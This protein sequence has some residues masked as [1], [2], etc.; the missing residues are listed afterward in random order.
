MGSLSNSLP[1]LLGLLFPLRQPLHSR[2]HFLCWRSS[3]THR[4]FP[5]Q[6]KTLP[7]FLPPSKSDASF[8]M[9]EMGVRKLPSSFPRKN[10]WRKFMFC[11]SFRALEIAAAGAGNIIS[12]SP[13]KTRRRK[14]QISIIFSRWLGGNLRGIHAVGR[15]IHLF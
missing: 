2:V 5:A 10:M 12:F 4:S 6:H 14:I 3:S 7:F 15:I 11:C 1:S 8:Q 13:I 9:G